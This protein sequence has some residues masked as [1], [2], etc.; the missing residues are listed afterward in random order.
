MLLGATSQLLWFPAAEVFQLTN[1]VKAQQSPNLFRC[2]TYHFNLVEIG[3][4]PCSLISE[5]EKLHS[6]LVPAIYEGTNV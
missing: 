3:D 2:G 6:D 1:K 5:A 4:I